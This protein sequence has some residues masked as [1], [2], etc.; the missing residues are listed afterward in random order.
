MAIIYTQ[1]KVYVINTKAENATLNPIYMCIIKDRTM[2]DYYFIIVFSFLFVPVLLACLGLYTTIAVFI[3]RRRRPGSGPITILRSFQ[4]KKDG[5]SQ[6]SNNYTTSS[7]QGTNLSL[8]SLQNPENSNISQ[9]MSN[10]KIK[11]KSLRS[12]KKVRSFKII[13]TLMAI[14][15]ICR[16]PSWVFNLVSIKYELQSEYEWFLPHIFSILSVINSSINPFLYCF[17]KETFN[18]YKI[19][20]N[21]FISCFTG[22][23]RFQVTVLK[24]NG[25]TLKIRNKQKLHSDIA[26]LEIENHDEFPSRSM[27]AISPYI[28][29]QAA[30]RKKTGPLVE[31]GLFRKPK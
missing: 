7:T 30:I 12:Q 5:K 20:K 29:D 17:L 15:F 21:K 26:A 25:D 13:L 14:F 8:D 6:T 19:I 3:W 18:V 11:T 4:E 2:R 27:E 22:C 9:S 31:K 1:V 28:C 24:R 16:L 10:K 23:C